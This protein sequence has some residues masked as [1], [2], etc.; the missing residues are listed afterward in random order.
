[1]WQPH[2]NMG[3]YTQGMGDSSRSTWVG[4]ELG[5]NEIKLTYSGYGRGRRG[6][7][8]KGF[9]A[10]LDDLR[11]GKASSSINGLDLTRNDVFKH[12]NWV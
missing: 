11:Q 6:I 10:I 1:M 8:G 5:T 3:Y 9:R 12:R 7:R 2:K 4:F